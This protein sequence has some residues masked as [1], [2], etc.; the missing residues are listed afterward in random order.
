[1]IL[2]DDFRD[3]YRGML[4]ESI[5]TFFEAITNSKE[6]K[7]A[8]MKEF[9]GDPIYAAVIKAT[10]AK[11]GK[12]A[13]KQLGDM[14]GPNAV[15]LFTN[16][17]KKLLGEQALEEWTISDVQIAM[18]KVNGKIDKEAIEKL[19]KVQHMGNV[20]RNALVKVG[21]GSLQVG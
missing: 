6:F 18:K 14:R 9:G 8:L 2:K 19:K 20:D 10:N 13:L 1:M 11:E 3:A 7:V 21:H 17:G 16:Y 15:K 12:A 4:N 5:S